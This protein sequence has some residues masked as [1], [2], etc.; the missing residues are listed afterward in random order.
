MFDL[1]HESRPLPFTETS[2]ACGALDVV[3]ELLEKKA[4]KN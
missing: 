1:S 2:Q 3:L 4:V